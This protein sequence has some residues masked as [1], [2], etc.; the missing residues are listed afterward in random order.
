[1][2]ETIEKL[3]PG[4]DRGIMEMPNKKFNLLTLSGLGRFLGVNRHTIMKWD[5]LGLIPD[6]KGIMCSWR[7]WLRDE[8]ILWLDAGMPT[9]E[10]WEMARKLEKMRR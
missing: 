5:A 3:A 9:R 7:Y 6:A 8:I 10:K 1:M 2:A 4:F